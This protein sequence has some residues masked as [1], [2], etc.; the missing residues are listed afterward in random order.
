MHAESS[1]C[2][3]GYLPVWLLTRCID[4]CRRLLDTCPSG[5]RIWWN[6][7]GNTGGVCLK[8]ADCCCKGNV[9]VS[10]LNCNYCCNKGYVGCHVGNDYGCYL[11][12]GWLY[13]WMQFCP[14]AATA[15]QCSTLHVT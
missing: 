13:R 9:Y 4:G 1:P 6:N 7:C 3:Q 2:R 15:R 11:G 10:P 5:E 14:T 12:G 8:D